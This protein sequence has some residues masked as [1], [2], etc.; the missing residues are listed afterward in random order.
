RSAWRSSRH[1]V[2]DAV[3]L[4]CSLC[5]PMAMRIRRLAGSAVLFMALGSTRLARATVADDLCKPTDDPCIV[6]GT[7]TLDP[8][9]VIELG[10]RGLEA[11]AAA[12]VTVGAGQV[13]IHAGSVELLAGARM[14]GSSGAA[15]S[16]LEIDSA[17]GIQIDAVGNT[18]A[19]I[20]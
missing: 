8:G 2:L 15:A 6:S 14:T 17:A 20:D 9:S 10:G 11:A 19:R 12:R 7:V 4:R 5:S 3:F 13:T 1:A 16:S 18:H